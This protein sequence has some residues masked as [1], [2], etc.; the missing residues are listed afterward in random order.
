MDW[1]AH[2]RYTAKLKRFAK[3]CARM[4]M[5]GNF[6]Y[7]LLCNV[8]GDKNEQQPETKVKRM[9]RSK[10]VQEMIES[11][12]LSLY[13]DEGITPKTVVKDE[14][15]I[16]DLAFNTNDL[17]NA[18]KIVH[19]WGSRIG[20]DPAKLQTTVTIEEVNYKAM[21]NEESKQIKPEPKQIEDKNE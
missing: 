6:D 2:E 5:S 16:L 7:K 13:E 10:T 4:K 18:V 1:K 9:L 17:S 11:E 15:D 21:L 19:K 20:L 12:I 14:N 8:Y 3:L